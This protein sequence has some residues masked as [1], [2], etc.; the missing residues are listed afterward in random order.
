MRP[1]KTLRAARSLWCQLLLSLSTIMVA[2]IRAAEVQQEPQGPS[3]CFGF[4]QNGDVY[5]KC[6]GT[7]QRITQLDSVT[8]FAV[9]A[10]GSRIAL[11]RSKGVGRRK[12]GRTIASA[13]LENARLRGGLPSHLLPATSFTG[14]VASCGTIFT[15]SGSSARNLDEGARL[16]FDLYNSFRCSSDRKVVVGT[17]ESECR[18]LKSGWPPD[19]DLVTASLHSRLYYDV[20][21]SGNFIASYADAKLCVR[22]GGKPARCVSDIDAFDRIS[23][24]DTGDVLFTTHWDGTCSYK[25]MWHISKKPLP[26]YDG[27]DQCIAVGAWRPDYSEPKILEALAR[28]PQWITSEVSAALR[29]WSSRQQASHSKQKS[30]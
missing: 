5:V 16:G 18:V 1:D 28:D 2:P 6:N 4:L 20:S 27:A 30:R 19:H 23:V 17:L 26:G 9:A 15:F 24:S 29:A 21:P 14:L 25:D 10:D 22:E 3:V 7:T 12:G 11:I 8:D 13:V